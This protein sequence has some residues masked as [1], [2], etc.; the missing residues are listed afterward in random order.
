MIIMIMFIN[1]K[2]INKYDNRGIK[3]TGR[4]IK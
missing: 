1:Q 3:R 4:S 2:K